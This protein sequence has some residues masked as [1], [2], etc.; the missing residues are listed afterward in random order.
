[1][2][3]LPY[4]KSYR[5][6]LV[7]QKSRVLAQKVFA[8]TKTFPKEERYGLTFMPCIIHLIST[9]LTILKYNSKN[10]CNINLREEIF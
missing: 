4:A 8:I 9:A 2:S 5:E 6:L 7:Y 10:S 3:Y 1:M